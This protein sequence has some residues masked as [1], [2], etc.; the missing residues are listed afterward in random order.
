[1][2]R[3]YIPVRDSILVE[4]PKKQF[5]NVTDSGIV[6]AM[7]EQD[8]LYGKVLAVGTG[9]WRET[10]ERYLEKTEDNKWVYHFID[11]EPGD[12]IVFEK[13]VFQIYDFENRNVVQNTVVLEEDNENQICLIKS[14]DVK[15]K[16]DSYSDVESNHM[17]GY[18][19]SGMTPKKVKLQSKKGIDW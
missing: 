4:V 15:L 13:T 8:F 7:I 12:L 16:I 2:K 19:F 1:M 18:M 5:Q 3:N 9:A 6:I 17:H 11:V 14:Y 10:Q